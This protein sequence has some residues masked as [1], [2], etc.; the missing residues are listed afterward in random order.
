MPGIVAVWTPQ[1]KLDALPGLRRSLKSLHTFGCDEPTVCSV[2]DCALGSILQSYLPQDRHLGER[3]VGDV[4]T[5]RSPGRHDY[6]PFALVADCRLDN[7]YELTRTLGIPAP[8][9]LSDTEI[10]IEAWRR[11]GERCVDHLVGAFAFAVWMPSTRTL[12]A[13]RDPVGE[14][15]LYLFRSPALTA[16]ASLPKAILA[17]DVPLRF[18]ESHLASWAALNPSPREASFFADITRI[19]PGSSVRLTPDKTEIHP[20]WHPSDVRPVRF[21]TDQ[22]YA[23]R[24]REILDEAT[25][26]RLRSRG[27]ASAQLSSGLDSSSVASSAALQL[28][29][30]GRELTAYTS[31]PQ[32]GFSGTHPNTNIYYDEGPFAAQIAAM[33]P[34]MRHV[35]V[36]SAGLPLLTI[37]KRWV[38]AMDEPVLNATNTVWIDT[39]LRLARANGSDIMFQGSMGNG[40]ISYESLRLMS[41]LLKK[42]RWLKLAEVVYRHRSSGFMSLRQAA[43][44]TFQDL[45]PA[46]FSRDLRERREAF[47]LEF[48]PLN[49]DTIQQ[50]SLYEQTAQRLI[51]QE[52]DIQ[53]ERCIMFERFDMGSFNAACRSLHHVDPRDP[54][55]DKRVWDYTYAIPPEQFVAD[56][57]SRSLIRRAMK[58]RLPLNT[59]LRYA[60]GHQGADWYFNMR[61]SLPELRAELEEQERSP[62]ASRYLDLPRL[63]YL[64]ETFPTQDFERARVFNPYHFALLRGITL[65]YFLRTHDPALKRPS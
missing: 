34:N 63:K 17:L 11:W 41:V 3:G 6:P 35:R 31:V 58:G 46:R 5:L 18:N 61:A 27:Q 57:H 29:P 60:R 43:R 20:Y 10:L 42:G 47:S 45:Y 28:A 25:G 53:V 24:M 62:A 56:G 14:V 50:F 36:S 12:F 59:L 38:D 13:A 2:E 1:Q 4:Q 33:Y 44:A 23:E 32:Q 8:E 22:Q 9:I 55:Y 21:G 39:I 19:P 40:N 15:P 64:V 26:V 16:L 30:L 48:C 7:R 65:G 37:V 49:E 52:A 51:A 54:T